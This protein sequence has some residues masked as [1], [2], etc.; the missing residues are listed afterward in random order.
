MTYVL[1]IFAFAGTFSKG[2]SNSITTQ[3]FTSKV[4]CLQAKKIAEDMTSGTL[5]KIVAECTVK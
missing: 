3:E 2:D 5:K 4:N 1:I